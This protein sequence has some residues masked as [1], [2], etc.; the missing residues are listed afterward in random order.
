MQGKDGAQQLAKLV[1]DAQRFFEY[2]GQS[3]M[4]H[5]LQAY[6]SATVFVPSGSIMRELVRAEEPNWV[7]VHG[8]M[9]EEHWSPRAQTIDPG[10]AKLEVVGPVTFSPDG[11]WLAAVLEGNYDKKT[12]RQVQIWDIVT[13]NSVWTLEDASGW[14]AFS[15][16]HTILGTVTSPGVVKFWDLTKG[17]WHHRV[18]TLLNVSAAVFSP[19]GIWL[20]AADGDRIGIWNWARGH[21]ALQFRHDSASPCCSVVYSAG[22][23]HL[24]SAHRDEIR[25]WNAQSGVLL[26]CINS[27]DTSSV[28]FLP[29]T[30]DSRL[31]SASNRTLIT[32][33][34][35]TGERLGMLDVPSEEDAYSAMALSADGSRFV[36]AP[37][38]NIMVWDTTTRRRLQTIWGYD[39]H[40]KALIFSPDGS[41]IASISKWGLRLYRITSTDGEVFQAARDHPDKINLIRISADGNTM[42]SASTSMMNI[43]DLTGACRRREINDTYNDILDMALSPDGTRLVSVSRG[44]DA[45]IWDVKTGNRLRI[46][47]Y[48]GFAVCFSPDGANIALLEPAG[49][50][51]VWS[52]VGQRCLQSFHQALRGE[53]GSGSVVFGPEDMILTSFDRSIRVW[54]LLRR[55]CNLEIDDKATATALVFSSDGHQ[56]AASYTDK[57]KIWDSKSGC[58]LQTLDTGGSNITVV[59]FDAARSRLLTNVGLVLLDEVPAGH[60][61]VRRELHRQGYG[62]NVTG[63]WVLWDSE[64]VLW[65]PPA[66]RPDSTA[67]ILPG[68]EASTLSAIVLGC[69]SG[70]VVVLRFPDSSKSAL[71]TAADPSEETDPS[72]AAVGDLSKK[73]DSSTLADLSKSTDLSEAEDPSEAADLSKLIDLSEATLSKAADPSASID[74][75]KSTDLSTAADRSES[76][77]ADL[78]KPA[79]LSKSVDQS[80]SAAALFKPTDPSKSADLSKA[81]SPTSVV[82]KLSTL[83]QPSSPLTVPC[84]E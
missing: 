84:F 6:T 21:R 31:I 22:G 77:A 52:L 75:S 24:A 64:K 74:L 11:A 17:I 26:R 62:V 4:E 60:V 73:A 13:G 16:K 40:I 66:Y 65:L 67:G 80:K 46:I 72:K 18:I 23:T 12:V 14:V 68:P 8:E 83:S 53:F 56:F 43:W 32:W 55:R 61:D 28:A 45:A 48:C 34:V 70:R 51:R 27:K 9:R 5:P 76:T 37:D 78:S 2:N 25:V 3:I 49:T 44:Q 71:P 10:N 38:G 15:P 33:S 20:A 54:K 58:C 79:D 57:I 29:D 47:P 30:A 42:A 81:A 82:L 35:K 36:V 69:R 41:Q 59:A 7:T 63:D 39:Q 19:D 1:V 50:I